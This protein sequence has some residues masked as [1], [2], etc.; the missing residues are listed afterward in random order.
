[1]KKTR[2]YN[3][4]RSTYLILAGL[5]GLILL[6]LWLIVQTTAEGIDTMHAAADWL[7]GFGSILLA[8]AIATYT[9]RLGQIHRQTAGKLKDTEH[10]FQALFASNPD[11]LLICNRQTLKFIDVNAA[12]VRTYGYSR[13]E[14]L[15]MT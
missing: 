6:V 2:W 14:F 12:A 9:L 7:L 11:P 13:D 10:R 8:I 5:V 4:S 15:Q 1:M 3:P